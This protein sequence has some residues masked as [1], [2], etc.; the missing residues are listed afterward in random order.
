MLENLSVPCKFNGCTETVTLAKRAQHI[1]ECPFNNYVKCIAGCGVYNDDLIRHLIQA[2]DYKEIIMEETGGMR[3]FSGPFDS[4]VR[5]TEW[6]RG[7]W[8]CGGSPIIVHART[9]C[10]VFHI[11]LFTTCKTLQKIQLEIEA[12]D[13]F[14]IKFVGKIPHARDFFE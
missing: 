6:P 5:D 13:E 11:Y 2:H 14:R 1:A 8:W 12:K 10:N 3:S 7:I 4:W 9:V